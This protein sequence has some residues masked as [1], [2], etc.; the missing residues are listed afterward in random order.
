MPGLLRAMAR[1]PLSLCWWHCGWLLDH[2]FLALTHRG[3]R[4]GKRCR[5]MLD[6]VVKQP[7]LVEPRPVRKAR[8]ARV[9]GR[10]VQAARSIEAGRARSGRRSHF[11]AGWTDRD[12]NGVANRIIEWVAL[13]DGWMLCLV[14]FALAFSESAAAV[15]LLVPG[16]VGMVV[17]G[18]AGER[19][20]TPLWLLLAA[21]TAG[22]VAGDQVSFHL[23]QRYGTALVDRWR[24]TRRHL[25]PKMRTARR[26]FDTHGGTTVF[27]ARWV[28]ALRAFVPFVAGTAEMSWRR[29]LVWNAL[30][31]T[32]WAVSVIT[33]GYVFGRPIAKLVDRFSV[34][35]TV[36]LVLLV[37]GWWAVVRVRNKHRG[38]ASD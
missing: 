35:S 15:D 22:A 36:G 29:F 3:R 6:V 10:A 37:V 27:V 9:R 7:P 24:F 16:E 31:A 20:G 4:S 33:L 28:G 30:G 17:A 38:I 19:A 21:G 26:H 32:T 34:W 5:T 23:G 11:R 18:A 25:R 8:D 1:T 14:L 2:R 13:L 12:R